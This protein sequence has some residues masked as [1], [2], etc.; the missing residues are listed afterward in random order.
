MLQ[1]VIRPSIDRPRIDRAGIF[2][3]VAGAAAGADL[4]D[5]GQDHVLG[6]ARPSGSSPSTSIRIVF[7]L[8][9]HQRLRRQHVLDLARADAE[10]QGAEGAVRAGVAVAA[11]DRGAGQREAQLGADDVDDA[12]A[13][14][15][16]VEQLDAELRGSCRVSVS[17]WMREVSSRDRLRAVARSGT[18]W[19]GT[20]SVSVGP[21]HLA[22][23]QPQALER[24]RAGHLVDEVPVDVEEAGAVRRSLD[25]VAV[26]DLLE[27]G[28]AP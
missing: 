1:T 10:G 16:H 12:L 8:L 5:D 25:D 7:G 19:S 24:L 14:V 28:R 4:A 6:G 15:V 9:L 18:L 17:T 23:G 22:A 11:D 21:A 26:P 13:D 2:D 27:Q 20:A 3:D